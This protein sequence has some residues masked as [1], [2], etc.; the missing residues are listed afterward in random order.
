L[1]LADERAGKRPDHQLLLE[2]PVA[3]GYSIG[4]I[5]VVNALKAAVAERLVA[6][7][8][9]PLVLTSPVL[10]GRERSHE[11]FQASYFDYRRRVRRL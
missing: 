4:G 8:K 6:F 3:P 7:G 5:A 9:P 2:E 1:S 10:A 11:L